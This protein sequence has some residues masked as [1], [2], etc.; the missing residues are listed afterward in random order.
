MSERGTRRAPQKSGNSLHEATLRLAAAL[1]QDGAPV[2]KLVLPRTP[3]LVTRAR[4]AAK[5]AGVAMHVDPIRANT[6]TLRFS[7]RADGGAVSADMP[8]GRARLR[9]LTRFLRPK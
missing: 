6:V 4:S 3:G 2:V 5:A 1:V 7:V 9:W 8:E